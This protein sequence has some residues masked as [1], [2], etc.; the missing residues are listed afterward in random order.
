MSE[1]TIEEFLRNN[2]LA[3]IQYGG[4]NISFVDDEKSFL[5]YGKHSKNVFLKTPNFCDA[6]E[7]FNNQIIEGN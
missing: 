2:R 6:W 3:R 4:L 5:V 1:I 7:V